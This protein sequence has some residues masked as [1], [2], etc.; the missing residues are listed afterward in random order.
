M[1]IMACMEQELMQ[2]AVAVLRIRKDGRLTK[3][4]LG[5]RSRTDRTW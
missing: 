1:C 2:E 4:V 3:V 5:D